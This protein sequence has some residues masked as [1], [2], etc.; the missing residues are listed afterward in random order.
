[1]ILVSSERVSRR[2]SSALPSGSPGVKAS[3]SAAVLSCAACHS[4]C[5]RPRLRDHAHS[6]AAV[7]SSSAVPSSSGPA[8]K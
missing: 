1:M 4:R 2:G 7:S 5:S 6:P 3:L 8:T